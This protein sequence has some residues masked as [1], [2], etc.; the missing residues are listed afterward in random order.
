MEEVPGTT[1]GLSLFIQYGEIMAA[2]SAE[3]GGEISSAFP[4]ATAVAA[5]P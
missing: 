4:A 1:T 3:A 5:G 2:R